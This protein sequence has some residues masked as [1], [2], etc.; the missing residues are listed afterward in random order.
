VPHL[1]ESWQEKHSM[2][3]KKKIIEIINCIQKSDQESLATIN[4]MEKLG[5]KENLNEINGNLK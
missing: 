5:F 1:K 3:T 2:K 4:L